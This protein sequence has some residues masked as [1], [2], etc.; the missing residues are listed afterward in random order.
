MT[1]LTTLP[2]RDGLHLHQHHQHN[3]LEHHQDL[4]HHPNQHRH[5][6]HQERNG[7]A[8]NNGSHHH[9]TKNNNNNN[10][11]Q[12]PRKNVKLRTEKVKVLELFPLLS[13]QQ[14]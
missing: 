1:T 7:K 13:I 14:T 9:Q 11:V 8:I 4:Q 3:H 12:T 2:V 6:R 10:N 5:N